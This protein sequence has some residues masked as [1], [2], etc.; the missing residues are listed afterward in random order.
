MFCTKCGKQVEDGMAFCTSCGNKMG[1]TTA[2]SNNPSNSSSTSM[3]KLG[4]PFTM[5]MVGN[6]S[7]PIRQVTGTLTI[8]S[9]TVEFKNMLPIGG[10][11][12]KVPVNQIAAV[13]R[14]TYA[15]INPS[16]MEIRLKDGKKYTLLLS[17]WEKEKAQRVVDLV[18]SLL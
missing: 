17:S 12:F 18:N 11:N 4:V 9:S 10:G 16:A 13:S 3:N 14:V 5:K 8:T 7:I 15:I 6:V 2:P 1:I